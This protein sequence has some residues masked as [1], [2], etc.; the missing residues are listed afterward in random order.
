MAKQDDK[1]GRAVQKARDSA[2]VVVGRARSQRSASGRR[3]KAGKIPSATS[4]TRTGASR[5]RQDA[6]LAGTVTM[7]ARVDADFA[8]ELVEADAPL[9]GL[10]GASDLVREGLRLVHIRAREAAMVA[11]YDEFYQGAAAPVPEG[12]AAIWGE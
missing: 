3:L 4:R 6:I 8:R 7:Q 11:A 2:T 1:G 12:T 5:P 10:S 9:L